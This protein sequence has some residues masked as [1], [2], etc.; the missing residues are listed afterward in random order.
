MRILMC[1]PGLPVN[2]EKIKG[3]VH[4]ATINLLKGF[5]ELP[6]EIRVV[7]FSREVFK[8]S[9]YIY[10]NNINI[11][12]FNEGLFSYHSLNY[13]TTGPFIIKK[14][15]K[16]FKPD[17]IHYQ[18]GNSFMLTRLLGVNRLPI[19]QTIHGMSLEEAKRKNKIK[20]KLIWYFNGFIQNIMTPENIIHLSEFSK[21]RH[22]KIKI[23]NEIIIPNAIKEECFNVKTNKQTSNNLIYIGIIDNNK[24]LFYLIETLNKL[25]KLNYRYTLEIIGGFN[26]EKYKKKVIDFIIAKE[27]SDQI[28]FHNWLTQ[29]STR[30][31]LAKSDILIV[32]S[33]H[34]S[35]PMVIAEAMAAGKAILASSVGGIPEMIEDKVNGYLYDLTTPQ[36][37][38]EYLIEL[39][40]NSKELF[41][42]GEK[43]KELAIKKYECKIVA[44]KTFDFY[45]KVIQTND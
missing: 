17:I 39:H 37:L 7:V 36:K 27:L 24:N 12:Y 32:C 8:K 43:G 19:I 1:V 6:V 31:V 42:M 40:N 21:K 13:I 44:N 35:L 5:I 2:I 10:S 28:T 15:I 3:G 30:E 23:K 33:K 38:I 9:T 29:S 16:E 25:N 14:Q 22:K 11:V 18:E 34:E 45:K 4:S 41:K 20:D 26:N